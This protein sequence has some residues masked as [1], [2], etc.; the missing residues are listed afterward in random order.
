M[1]QHASNPAAE[2]GVNTPSKSAPLKGVHD[3]TIYGVLNGGRGSQSWFDKCNAL[4]AA[5]VAAGWTPPAGHPLLMEA[6][7]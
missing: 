1:V 6:R 7:K 3:E 2:S 5:L 4:E